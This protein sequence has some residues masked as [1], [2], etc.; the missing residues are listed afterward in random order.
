MVERSK[1]TKIIQCDGMPIYAYSSS[2]LIPLYKVAHECG[3]RLDKLCSVLEISTR[4]FRRLF[5]D[6]IGVCPKKWLKSERMV[7]ARNL[8][9]GGYPIKEVSERLGFGNQKEFNREFREFYA[10]SPSSYRAQET[11][12]VLEKLR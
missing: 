11:E 10:I 3:Y 6:T 2:R 5:T 4:H 8:L 1:E 12:R 7:Y 9:R